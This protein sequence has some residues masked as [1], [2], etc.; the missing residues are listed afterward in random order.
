MTEEIIMVGGKRGT[1]G[2]DRIL[3]K[4]VQ[5]FSRGL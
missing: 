2:E 1:K 4:K 3:E 5:F